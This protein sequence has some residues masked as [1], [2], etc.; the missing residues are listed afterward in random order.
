MLFKVLPDLGE[1]HLVVA[2][3]ALLLSFDISLS[4]QV[5]FSKHIKCS[6]KTR[7][8][9][10]L[11]LLSVALLCKLFSFLDDSLGASLDHG[12]SGVNKFHSDPELLC[13]LSWL[14]LLLKVQ[15]SYLHLL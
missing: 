5:D 3:S 9:Q 2:L 11:I 7:V 14:H 15:M 4:E 12:S 1:Q 10:G 8:S 13:N 6:K